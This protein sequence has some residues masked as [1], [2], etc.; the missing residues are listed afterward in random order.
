[1]S[2]ASAGEVKSRTERFRPQ[3]LALMSREPMRGAPGAAF[4]VVCVFG[5]HER[6]PLCKTQSC[7]RPGKS[8]TIPSTP[9]ES[10]DSISPRSL[11]VQT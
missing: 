3:Q 11:I 1:M 9:R 8:V 2:P 7:I 6:C 10:S 5:T 4:D